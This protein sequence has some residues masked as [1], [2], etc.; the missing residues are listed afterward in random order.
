MFWPNFLMFSSP[1]DF[2]GERK[3]DRHGNHIWVLSELLSTI[4]T[5][6]RVI[7]P[8]MFLFFSSFAMAQ[9]WKRTMNWY[10]GD[11]AGL[12]FATDPPT[13]LTDG[14]MSTIEG[15]ATMSDTNGNLLFYTN[16]VTVWNK[17]HQVMKNGTG[18]LSN[19]TYAQAALIVPQ[20]GNDSIY[21][22]FTPGNYL[23]YSIVNMNREGG[24]GE[25]TDKNINLIISG[26]EKLAATH[27]ANRH[28]VWVATH[29]VNN[30]H[31]IAFL[32]TAKGVISCPVISAVG[33]IMPL[34]P[35]QQ[36]EMHFSP[37]GKL[38]CISFWNM[39]F[40]EL[41]K[42]DNRDGKFSDPIKIVTSPGWISG[43]IF[44]PN[45]KQMLLSARER[46]IRS[47]NLTHMDELSINRDYKTI[48]TGNDINC[49]FAYSYK[50][51]VF[52]NW[53]GKNYLGKI[54][55]S[56]TDTTITFIDSA[57]SIAPRKG[58]YG[59]P[60]FISSYFYYPELDI[61]YRT[62]CE[63]DTFFFEGKF[64]DISPSPFWNIIRKGISIY[65]SDQSTFSYVFPDTGEY[66]VRL[67]SNSDTAVKTI[68]IEPK[69][70][71]RQD[72]VICNQSSF[73]INIPNN[74]RCIAWQDGSDSQHYTIT[75][76]GAYYVSGYNI[77]GCL[78]SD[79]VKIT[80]AALA[81]P[82]ITK[83]NDSLITDS[84]NYNYKWRYNG[85]IIPG[86]THIIN[87]SNN[88]VYNV[89]IS[90]SNGCT[91]TSTNFL[92]SGLGNQ[93]FNTQD[94]F[95]VYPIPAS[96][97]L[98]IQPKEKLIVES[99]SLTDITGRKFE[100]SPTTELFLHGLS[101]GIYFLKITDN[102]SKTYVTKIIIN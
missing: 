91:N 14:A 45:E 2:K 54:V 25:V 96:D 93:L 51:E 18:L 68:Y 28:D 8:F 31:F 95:I 65:S 83:K 42:F 23:R 85:E 41:L 7:I 43:I 50:N 76:N 12:S 40:V 63:N 60:Q 57:V 52:F 4:A 55:F 1:T 84:G 77:K 37:S 20:P 102:Q 33:S 47:Y 75:E 36:L 35:E 16:G 79:T 80:F 32:V 21:F 13:A 56:H 81:A 27:H 26:T 78:V 69:L 64:T 17:S 46:W 70:D 15:C 48:Y 39:G 6:M 3:F 101:K 34:G 5:T 97:K 99:L 86:N 59:M 88:G 30:N 94:F 82:V 74:F 10:F 49:Q 11:K 58:L 92:V 90:D 71:L 100:F 29:G 67:V 62:G 44:S 24:L 66:L 72:T 53:A 98:F 22:I 89:E 9:D 19:Q 87:V 73:A 38:S 61:T